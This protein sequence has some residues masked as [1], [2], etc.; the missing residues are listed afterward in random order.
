MEVNDAMVDKLAHLARLK[1]NSE[2]KE[3]IKADLQRMIAFVEKLNELDLE[4]VEPLLHMSE[5][6]NVLRD[7]EVKGS[8]TREDALKNAPD[9]DEEFFKVPKVIK[10]AQS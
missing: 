9:H 4:G 1:F 6:V 2:E 8:V 7:D 5:E 3:E 10:N